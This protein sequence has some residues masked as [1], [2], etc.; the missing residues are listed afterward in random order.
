MSRS[1]EAR[2]DFAGEERLFRLRVGPLN[3]LQEK[4]DAGPLWLNSM[5]EAGRWKTTD[6]REIIFQGL[7]G[8]GMPDADATALIKSDFDDPPAGYAQFV[9][10]CRAIL[11]PVIFG[12]EDEPLGEPAGEGAMTTSPE[13]NSAS[14][15]ST[16]P[17]RP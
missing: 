13:A 3:A 10:L 4:L 12:V 2:L 6:L 7:K 9:P 14:P 11:A 5:L 16:E 8:G 1:A 15:V 17:E